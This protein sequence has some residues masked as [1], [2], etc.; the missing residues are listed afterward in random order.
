MPLSALEVQSVRESNFTNAGP[1][2]FGS[3]DTVQG[4]FNADKGIRYYS[5]IAVYK[6]SFDLPAAADTGKN[7]RLYLDLGK[8]KNMA[9]VIF[10]GKDL[11]VVWTAPWKVDI[12]GLVKQKDN[13]LEISVANLWPNRLIGDDQLPQ[14]GIKNDK[15]PEWLLKG[16][17]RTSGRYAFTTYDPYNK[18]SP[19]LES[20]LLGPVTIF[21]EVD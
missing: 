14:D 11:G 6:K 17:P 9:R 7:D 18:D 10:N 13:Q 20:G 4:P 5:G 21:K 3:K 1:P 19:L 16:E 8:V 12:T 2:H 15:F